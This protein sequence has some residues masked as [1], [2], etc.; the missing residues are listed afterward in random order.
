MNCLVVGYGSIGQRHV[1][2]LQG[3]V[4]RVA[5]VSK[6]PVAY[7]IRYFTLSE[8]LMKEKPHYIVIANETHRHYETLQELIGLGFQGIILMEKPL[9][10]QYFPSFS[11]GLKGLYV[12]Y[13][14]RFHPIIQGLKDMLRHE[15]A[16][17]C[18]V[19]VGQYLPHWRPNQDY[20]SCYSA[21]TAKGGGVLLDLSHELDYLEWLLGPWQAMVARGGKYSSL[22]INSDDLW[23]LMMVMEGCPMVQVHM[24]YL[25]PVAR[26]EATLLTEG[27]SYRADLVNHRLQINDEVIQYQL[28][29]DD[30][31]EMEH[32][33]ILEGSFDKLCTW[34]QGLTVLKMVEAARK[35]LKEGGWVF[36]K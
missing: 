4:N 5:V 19:Y 25:D 1:R 15:R 31:Y 20:R 12:G 28:Q 3:L 26:R 2:V 35:S 29:R 34:Q 11:H 18:Q 10:H 23:S 30:T 17:Y 13:N 6:R 7:P 32:R 16:L 24:N 27:N 8:A 22:K 36:G 21:D 14:L 9:F 33:A